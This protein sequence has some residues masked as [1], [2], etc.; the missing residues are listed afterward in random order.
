MDEQTPSQTV[1]DQQI[2]CFDSLRSFSDVNQRWNAQRARENDRMRGLSS[3]F[4]NQLL[5]GTRTRA[6]LLKNA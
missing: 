1:Y 3:L 6:N 2:T 5:M 4:Q